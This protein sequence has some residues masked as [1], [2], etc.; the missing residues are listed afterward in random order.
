LADWHSTEAGR[1]SLARFAR[2]IKDPDYKV[3]NPITQAN[4]SFKMRESS[5]PQVRVI[6]ELRERIGSVETRL[7]DLRGIRVPDMPAIQQEL[8][9]DAI[10]EILKLITR[11]STYMERQDIEGYIMEEA[12]V[13]GI[14]IDKI[15]VNDRVKPS[16]IK[17]Y[18][19]DKRYRYV[20]P[21][22][23]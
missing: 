22:R 21:T 23:K 18:I 14:T 6:A 11:N 15:E 19:G 10:H 12:R 7:Q 3:S 8:Q 17:I 9:T 13:R 16:D 4:A 1:S 20:G 5:D 2:A